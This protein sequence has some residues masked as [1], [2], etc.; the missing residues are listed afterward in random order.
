MAIYHFHTAPISR[1]TGRSAVAA[2]AY[3]AAEKLKD[4][5]Y[6]VVHNYKQKSG[7][8]HTEVVA[9]AHALPWTFDREALWNRAESA[10]TR[11]NARVAREIR[12]ALPH[13]LSLAQQKELVY[14]QAN[15]L[16]ERYGVVVDVAIHSPD[17][18]GD[19]RNIHAHLL[20]STRVISENGFGEKSDLEQSNANLKKR[21]L[22]VTQKQIEAL[23]AQWAHLVNQSFSSLEIQESVDHRSYKSQGISKIPTTHLGP[24]AT[25]MERRNECSDRGE[26]NREVEKTNGKIIA[27][28]ETQEAIRELQNLRKNEFGD[29]K[30][31]SS[32]EEFLSNLETQGL[33]IQRK[34]L[35]QESHSR[36]L[37]QAIEM[38]VL[39][40]ESRKKKDPLYTD[41]EKRIAENDRKLFKIYENISSYKYRGS[42]AKISYW[43]ASQGLFV[44]GKSASLYAEY[45]SAVDEKQ[46][47][48][49]EKN[50]VLRTL[51]SVQ[52]HSSFESQMVA[53]FKKRD[54]YKQVLIDSESQE[55]RL[56]AMQQR[57]FARA[58]PLQEQEN[59][60]AHEHNEKRILLYKKYEDTLEALRENGLYDPQVRA[61]HRRLE[62]ESH[63][64]FKEKG[65]KI[66]DI[67]KACRRNYSPSPETVGELY[68]ERQR[69]L[70]RGRGRGFRR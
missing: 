19:E 10:E 29:L 70:R 61:R 46:A 39:D 57:L 36:A 48:S 45:A 24:S 51:N 32:V 25:A 37:R 59:L 34:V 21:N 64:L 28:G 50:E 53:D 14:R 41:I 67:E 15:A 66:W 3:R 52:K 2:A 20:L 11:K 62:K 63:V 7:V 23:R 42:I 55:V 54:R 27:L 8:L 22:P 60:R 31:F 68:S 35:D 4:E 6:G 44:F 38:P 9:P 33:A 40:I 12:I 13:E 65:K 18:R 17:K 5:R 30:N 1:S 56:R 43:C 69:S 16:V 26:I 58:K 47:L 49:E